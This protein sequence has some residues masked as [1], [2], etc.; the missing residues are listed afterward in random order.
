[1]LTS[2]KILTNIRDLKNTLQLVIGGLCVSCLSQLSMWEIK[3]K[4]SS[5]CLNHGLKLYH[6]WQLYLCVSVFHQDTPLLNWI[7]ANVWECAA[8][9]CS[10]SVPIIDSWGF[11]TGTL[12]VLLFFMFT[13]TLSSQDLEIPQLLYSLKSGLTLLVTWH[14]QNCST[15]AHAWKL[16][17]QMWIRFLERL[18]H[19][20]SEDAVQFCVI[21][22]N[23]CQ[24][25]CACVFFVCLYSEFLGK[26]TCISAFSVRL[27][28]T[29]HT[30]RRW[31]MKRW[32]QSLYSSCF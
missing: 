18:F 23:D 24:F 5:S 19:V 4:N 26:I 29:L 15:H 30:Q 32:S 21:L 13:E 17:S 22:M 27:Y 1:M 6:Q 10:C 2:V 3:W 31:V 28:T 7:V 11:R 8:R 12:N 16:G 9:F 14:K 25:C 20:V